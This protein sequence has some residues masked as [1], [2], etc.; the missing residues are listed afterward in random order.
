M[1]SHNI[2]VEFMKSDFKDISDS[3]LENIAIK[4]GIPANK[5]V[6]K[7]F[8]PKKKSV[9]AKAKSALTGSKRQSKKTAAKKEEPVEEKPAEEEPA[10]EEKSDE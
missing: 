3:V 7:L 9:A 6:D 4:L 2:T 8:P 1:D 10:E 5:V